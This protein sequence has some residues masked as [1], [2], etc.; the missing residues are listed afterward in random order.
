[1]VET[2]AELPFIGDQ[3]GLLKPRPGQFLLPSGRTTAVKE[4][5]AELLF[6]GDQV[7][8]LSHEPGRPQRNAIPRSL[9]TFLCKSNIEMTPL[10]KVEVILARVLGS[11]EVH[12]GGGVVDEQAGVQPS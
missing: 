7:V 4:T 12:R 1:M 2:R 8:C 11:G 10:C 3:I 5:L 9:E 6:I